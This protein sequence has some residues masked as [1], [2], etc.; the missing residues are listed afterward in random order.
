MDRIA[1]RERRRF[2]RNH[3]GTFFRGVLTHLLRVALKNVPQKVHKH[4]FYLKAVS[5]DGYDRPSLGSGAE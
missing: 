4:S 2:G 3:I 5:D 1:K